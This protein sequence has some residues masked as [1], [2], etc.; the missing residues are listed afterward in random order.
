[1]KKIFNDLKAKS[2]IIPDIITYTDCINSCVL[3]GDIPAAL[4]YFEEL[5]TKK[6]IPNIFTYNVL[7]RVLAEG[8]FF[9]KL[10]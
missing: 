3:S 5:K 10:F 6:M 2:K 1:M 4:E 8:T 9:P 7:L